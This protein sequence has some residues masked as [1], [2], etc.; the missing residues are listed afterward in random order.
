MN[1][2]S[3]GWSNATDNRFCGQCGTAFPV[4]CPS[5][6]ALL[7]A[8][9]PF[10]GQCGEAVP[11]A[12]GAAQGGAATQ[13]PPSIS[14]LRL[15]SVLFVDLVEYTPLTQGWDAEEVRQLLTGYYEVASTIVQRYGG[16]VEKFIGDAVV[17]AWGARL[18]RE[19]DAARAV[20]AGLE[21]VAAVS[22]HGEANRVPGL[23]ARAGV[24][25]GQVASWSGAGPGLV[26]GDRVNLAARVQSGAEPGGVLVDDVTMRATRSSVAYADAGERLLKGFSEP[27]ALWRALRALAPRGGAR[28]AD[29]LEASFVGRS[30]ELSMVKELF[31]ATSAEGRARLVAVS[32]VAGIGKSRLAWEFGSST[33]RGS[34]TRSSGTAVV[35]RRTATGSRSGPLPR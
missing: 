32:G 27:L 3:C 25:T 29:A 2:E 11:G 14:E 33:S 12:A 21:I 8:G 13:G 6:G 22:A 4:G 23:A 19:D 31:H 18:S 9:Q 5:C 34:S 17:A 16:V 7:P 30:R 15:A 28:G 20:R 26:A 24:V 35:A 1:C 10:C